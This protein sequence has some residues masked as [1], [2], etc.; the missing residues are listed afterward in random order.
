MKNLKTEVKGNVLLITVDLAQEH[1]LSK[2]GKTKM[3][4]TTGGNAEVT[5]GVYLG[6][7]VYKYAT[8]KR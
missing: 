8:P 5:E 2:S 7:N 6:L 3:I 1:G 4:A